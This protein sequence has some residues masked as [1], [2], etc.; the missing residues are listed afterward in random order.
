M[1]EP[2]NR[3]GLLRALV[4]S[5]GESFGKELAEAVEAVQ[6]PFESAAAEHASAEAAPPPPLA[7]VAAVGRSLTVAELLELASEEGLGDRH[8]ALR[9]LARPSTLLTPTF[10]T[11]PD[12]SRIG[13]PAE[14]AR[15]DGTL[16]AVAD[17]DLADP[18]LAGG[19]LSGA[20]RL[21]VLIPVPRGA[22]VPRCGRAH[23]RVE[24]EI[25]AAGTL[26]LP[27]HLST[28]LTLPRVWAAPVQALD[29]DDA[30]HAAYVRLRA[31]VAELQGV[32]LEDGDAEGVARHHLLGYPTE[33]SGTMPLACELA[34]RGLDPDT[35]GT[36]V[37][38]D[39]VAASERWRLL[40][41]V[42]E[43]RGSGVTLAP[44]AARLFFWIAEDRLECG[45]FSE[46]W[47]I[48]R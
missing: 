31:R 40:L 19:A 30:E 38:Q 4:R 43:D 24:P 11:A 18:A 9:A 14:T 21:V 8:E 23:V 45:D 48:A 42:T 10:G 29:L 46:V 41:Q 35:P 32:P 3:R 22:P 20:G 28:A 33:T 27:V 17:V 47:A 6:A 44:G 16:A 37:P 13:R 5:A 34:S 25:L 1:A 15:A 7:Q 2:T 26:G 36:D 12:R 39:A